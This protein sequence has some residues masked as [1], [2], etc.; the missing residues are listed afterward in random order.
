MLYRISTL[1]YVESADGKILLL[2]RKKAPN[3]G[4]WSPIGG[5]LEMATGESPFEAARRETEEEIGVTLSDD[6]LHLFAI[7]AEKN[8]ESSGHWLMFLF[9]AHPKL[10]SL[11]ATIDEGHFAFFSRGEIDA[12]P[13]PETDRQAL[14]PIYDKHRT[15]FVSLRAD[16]ATGGPLEFTIEQVTV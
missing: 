3:Q 12:L 13:I 9:V 6:D 11:P 5:K 10:E 4:L 1:I 7:I 2:Q 8:Y 14:W 16:C 15:G